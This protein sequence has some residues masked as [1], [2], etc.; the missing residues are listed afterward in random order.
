MR[1]PHL[2]AWLA[3]AFLFAGC[4]DGTPGAK[5]PGDIATVDVQAPPDRPDSPPPPD[6]STTPTQPKRDVPPADPGPP[7]PAPVAAPGPSA[8]S[9]GTA[10]FSGASSAPPPA[11]Q[12][13]AATDAA[14]MVPAGSTLSALFAR[15][16]TLELP[17]QLLP[18]RCYAILAAGAPTVQATQITVAATMP[19]LPPTVLAQ[20]SGAAA[21]SLGGKSTGCYKN[22][23]PI[24]L[25]ATV[26][27]E[28][29]AGTGPASI[30]VYSK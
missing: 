14:G 9:G 28:V 30:Q 2:P 16:Q 24:P 19:P 25:T 13:L 22:P 21:A 12:A 23:M 6:A 11:I 4:G 1:T 5:T 10:T 15:G 17:L 29:T 3:L 7:P 26:T 20:A 8:P 27:V 18:G